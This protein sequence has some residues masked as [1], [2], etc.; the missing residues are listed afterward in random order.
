[1]RDKLRLLLLYALRF[2]AHTNND[3]HGL[4]DLLTKR[5]LPEKDR[6]V[7]I[8]LLQALWRVQNSLSSPLTLYPPDG[9]VHTGLR[10]TEETLYGPIWHAVPNVRHTQVLP[11]AERSGEYLHS[12]HATARRNTRPA[13]QR[14]AEGVSVPIYDRERDAGEVRVPYSD[15]L[16]G[17]WDGGL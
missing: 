13:C 6:R 7:S 10:W 16:A 8:S 9:G 2:E 12:A 3:L 11:R 15:R 5:G 17:V 4:V 1:M 14:Q